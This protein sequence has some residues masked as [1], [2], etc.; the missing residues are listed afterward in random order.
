MKV[1]IT[2]PVLSHKT[3]IKLLPGRLI[4]GSLYPA[5]RLLMRLPG[6]KRAGTGGEK[7]SHSTLYQDLDIQHLCVK[8]T[9]C[10]QT[11]VGLS[12]SP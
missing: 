9:Y 3:L 12:E 4:L 1:S 8:C 2:W 11:P 5:S 7:S 6:A 10:S